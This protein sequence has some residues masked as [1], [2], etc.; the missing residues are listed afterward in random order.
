MSN[1]ASV[2]LLVIWEDE[3]RTAARLLRIAREETDEAKVSSLMGDAYAACEV[4]LAGITDDVAVV[5]LG[6]KDLH[7]SVLSSKK[8]REAKHD[9]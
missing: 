8:R 9:R 3:I 6:N 2:N 7:D 4:A 1:S 5:M